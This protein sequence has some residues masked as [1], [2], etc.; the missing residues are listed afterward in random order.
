MSNIIG[1]DAARP[2][3]VSDACCAECHHRWV[4][5]VPDLP[6][7]R[8]SLECPACG[9]MTDAAAY[10]RVD[11]ALQVLDDLREKVISGEIVAF[12]AVGIA[13]D[14]GTLAWCS[15]TQDVS[16]LRV[17]GAIAHLGH[18]YSHGDV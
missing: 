12:A 14:D 8:A 5:V 3:V 16:R 6:T 18:M 1:L 15:A 2:H 7:A 9:A 11:R 10:A 4:A 17:I 13:P